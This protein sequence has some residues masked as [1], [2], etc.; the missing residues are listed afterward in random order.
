M[1]VLPGLFSS[2]WSALL[3]SAFAV[4]SQ[5]RTQKGLKEESVAGLKF[6]SSFLN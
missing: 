3:V 6:R 5:L 1:V 2:V 4:L